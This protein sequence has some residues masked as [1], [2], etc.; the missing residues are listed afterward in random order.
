MTFL[1]I[2]IQLQDRRCL[3]VGG[4]AV[5]ARKVGR[6]LRAGAR[7]TVVAP[8]LCRELSERRDLGEIE[9]EAR[10]FVRQDLDGAWLCIAATDDAAQ[11][12]QVS[13]LAQERHI[14]VN[15]VDDPERCTFIMPSV[16]DR[17]PVQI[18]ISTGG[19][20]P[21]LA[22]L[23]RARLETLVPAAYGRLAVLMAAFRERV[24]QRFRD[25]GARRRFWETVLH[26][27]VAEMLFAG[28]DEAALAALAKALDEGSEAP[29]SVGE[30]YLVGAGPGNPDLLTFRALRLMQQAD[31]VLY[32]RLVAPAILDLV[33]KDAERVHVGKA[34][35]EHRLAQKAINDLLVDLALEGKRV[36]RLKGGDPFIFGRGGEEIDTLSAHGIP[37]QVVPG[38]TAASGCAAYAGIP[39]THRDYAHS[40]VFVTGHLQDG[41]MDLNWDVLV[42]P[43][44]TVAVYMGLSGLPVL[45][46][47]LIARGMAPATP[48]ALIEQGTT[49]RQRVFTGTL[50]GL[51]EVIAEQ[52]VHAPTLVIVGEVVRLR[53]K[54]AWFAPG[55]PR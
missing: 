13:A 26:G 55:D 18:A 44:Q 5:A 51:P 32:D 48:A 2:F 40:C 6:L 31:I 16:V 24:K 38:I 12:G 46:R 28:R 52:D 7:V 29:L 23:L 49:A 15:V 27:P 39:L 10:A 50:E 9:H 54:L 17:S 36:L 42:Q 11:N 22:R 8:D 41:S 37:F 19:A 20:S 4:G 1:P 33:R 14:P 47:E 35:D 45:C 43:R 53:E 25:V 3:V 34:R 21:V 30:V